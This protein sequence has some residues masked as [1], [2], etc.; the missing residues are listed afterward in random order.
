MVLAVRM[1]VDARGVVVDEVTPRMLTH[2]PML[3]GGTDIIL[4]GDYHPDQGWLDFMR[5]AVFFARRTVVSNQKPTLPIDPN[6]SE[7]AK[8]KRFK[9]K[10]DSRYASMPPE[11]RNMY[12]YGVNAA[13]QYQLPFDEFRYLSSKEFTKMKE[14]KFPGWEKNGETVH[15]F[16]FKGS[17]ENVR[18]WC[19][20]NIKGRF[21]IRT[22]MAFFQ[23]A[24]DCI[25]ARL[26]FG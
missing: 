9:K 18:E 24:N 25:H 13:D 10:Y 6:D 5:G 7:K 1:D 15:F 17:S 2:I 16:T 22:Q 4:S 20:D 3:I 21:S 19:K 12:D 14:A 23:Y 26:V 8:Y 11:C